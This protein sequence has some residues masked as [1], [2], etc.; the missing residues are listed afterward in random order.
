MERGKSPERHLIINKLSGN[1]VQLSQHKFAS[2]VVE[3]CLEYGD[4][5]SLD[6]IIG[7]IIGHE[8]GNDNLLVSQMNSLVWIVWLYRNAW[9]FVM[10]II[11][12]I[13]HY[14]YTSHV[15]CSSVA[16]YFHVTVLPFLVWMLINTSHYPCN[17]VIQCSIQPTITPENGHGKFDIARH[18][19]VTH[20][21]SCGLRY[22]L[23]PIFDVRL[24]IVWALYSAFNHLKNV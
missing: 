15:P 24:W 21:L 10:L 9:E 3:K 4:S 7:E 11:I 1:I 17:H 14:L 16:K 20:V 23:I 8:D 19:N 6:I 22:Q 18:S 5:N 2:N 13:C 12:L